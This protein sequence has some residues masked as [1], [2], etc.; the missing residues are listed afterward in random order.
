M[1]GL[2]LKSGVAL[3]VALFGQIFDELSKFPLVREDGKIKEGTAVFVSLYAIM[4]INH[5]F[6][7]ADV[8]A[9]VKSLHLRILSFVERAA[10][11]RLLTVSASVKNHGVAHFVFAFSYIYVGRLG[12]SHDGFD[13]VIVVTF[14]HL[15]GGS[16]H[17]VDTQG[18]VAVPLHF[19]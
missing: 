11:R 19:P 6:R 5:V 4:M 1:S 18:E 15:F 2:G 17:G 13:D 8:V 9:D 7:F 12:D 16:T 10:W 3:L 14:D